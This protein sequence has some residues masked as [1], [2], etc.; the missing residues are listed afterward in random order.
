M[1][2]IDDEQVE[3]TPFLRSRSAYAR[4]KTGRSINLSVLKLDG[5]LF[6][7]QV[8]KNATVADLRSVIEE[9]F[10][11]LP[12]EDGCEIS[13]SHVWGH[14]CLCFDD[15]KLIKDNASIR[16][17]GISDGDQLHFVRHMTVDY[18]PLKRH[19]K[20]LHIASKSSFVSFFNGRRI[21][22]QAT[23]DEHP[24]RADFS[25]DDYMG[26][27]TPNRREFW[28]G[29]SLRGWLSYSVRRGASRKR[30]ERKI[31]PSGFAS[32]STGS[33]LDIEL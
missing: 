26:E 2:A 5:S 14:F 17:Y 30:S 28:S 19:S 8:A 20:N 10:S 29:H 16:N 32:H 11:S 1:I 18:K 27:E 4:L 31:R 13:W 7:V 21:K 15:Q 23:A 22:K 12:Q 9:V 3:T 6:N 24:A 33:L 25:H